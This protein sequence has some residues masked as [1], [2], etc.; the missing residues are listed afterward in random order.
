MELRQ[1]AANTRRLL[2]HEPLNLD[3]PVSG[4]EGL[5]FTGEHDVFTT[6][7]HCQDIAGAFDHAW[8][9]T[10]QRADHLFHIEQFDT[11]VELLLRFMRGRVHGS[12]AGCEALAPVGRL[13]ISATD[14]IYVGD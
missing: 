6:P 9:T 12:I 2:D 10:I 4:P 8:L 7:D 3:V 1:Y 5:V 14:R 13:S 11:V